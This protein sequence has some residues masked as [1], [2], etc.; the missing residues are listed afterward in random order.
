M[1]KVLLKSATNTIVRMLGAVDKVTASI[2]NVAEMAVEATSTSLVEQK[3]DN[4]IEIV[5]L[6]QKVKDLGVDPKDIGLSP[7]DLGLE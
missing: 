3:I 7:K 6:A 2:D 1:I 4:R 5:K